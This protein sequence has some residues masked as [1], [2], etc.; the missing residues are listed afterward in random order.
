MLSRRALL[1]AGLVSLAAWWLQPALPLGAKG[2][3][4]RPVVLQGAMQSEVQALVAALEHPVEER[5]HG[6]SFWKGSL[7]GHAVVISKT[8][9]GMANAA[10]ATALA[11]ERYQPIAIINQGTAGGHD[12]AL[13]VWDI[14]VGTA[15]VN[16]GAF[17]TGRRA[18]GEGTSFA[19]WKPL[20]L[21]GT[22]GSA[23]QDPNA[24][25]MRRFDA[26]A[27]LL[28]TARQAKGTYKKGQV[29]EGIIA[30]SDVWNS[31][32]DRIQ[33]F[34][35]EFGTTVEEMETAAAA[36]VSALAQV[37]F[38]GI[39]VVSNNITNDGAYDPRSAEGSQVF[40]IEVVRALVGAPAAK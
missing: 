26:D 22:E 36:Q 24:W 18:R 1:M 25:K 13:R 14:V 31:E 20:D 32:L 16:I 38:L 5:V 3:V 11:V 17:K 19:E 4:E 39:R 40:V 28:A 7:A 34:H 29:V 12:P 15:A 21:V 2:K 23:G 27:D 35:D 10:A 6:W 37:P 33:R 9:K 30:S 8:Q